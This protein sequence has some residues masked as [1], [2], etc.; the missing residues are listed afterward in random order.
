MSWYTTGYEEVDAMPDADDSD[1][2][3]E[4]R[5]HWMKAQETKQILFIDGSPE[6][7]KMFDRKYCAPFCYFEHQVPLLRGS[8]TDWG[9]FYT[10]LHGR[11]HPKTGERMRCVICESKDV[12]AKR[13]YVGLYTIVDM[14]GYVD[15]N[16]QQQG[17]GRM[18]ILPAKKR[19]LKTLQRHQNRQGSLRGCLY[20][21]Y[22][23]GKKV[24]NTGDDWQFIRK[25]SEDEIME[26]CN[27]K[28][29]EDTY[30]FDYLE[31]SKPKSRKEIMADLRLLAPTDDDNSP[32]K[33]KVV[34]HDEQDIPF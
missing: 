15:K 25:L 34:E 32:T 5:R 16:G 2:G 17:V 23:T 20:D 13:Y 27:A 11:E 14:T 1:W 22:R 18:M 6:D 26:A 30:P 3:D 4:I 8:R 28:S 33:A 24:A 21:V 9:N 29:P 12:D 10:C 19:L 7:K 31:Y